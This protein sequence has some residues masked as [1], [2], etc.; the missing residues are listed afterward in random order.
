M[1][2]HTYVRAHKQV[3]EYLQ[4]FMQYDF[5]WK[6]DKQSAY[7]TLM[8]TN[9]DLDAFEQEL[10]KYAEIET[11]INNIPPVL[12]RLCLFVCMHCLLVCMCDCR[13]VCVHALVLTFHVCGKVESCCNVRVCVTLHCHRFLCIL[14]AC[15]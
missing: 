12:K 9:P 1:F 13:T 8:R 15:M 14:G 7:D 3:H 2:P 11:R 10:Q 4:T 5:L 6:E